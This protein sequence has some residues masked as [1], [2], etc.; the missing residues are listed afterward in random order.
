MEFQLHNF[1]WLLWDPVFLG[2]G[3]C[4]ENEG[5]IAQSLYLWKEIKLE[6]FL[7]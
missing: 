2:L 6:Q 1:Q 5:A 3:Q 4:F 7:K